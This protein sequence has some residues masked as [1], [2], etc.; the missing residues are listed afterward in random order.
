MPIEELVMAGGGTGLG[1]CWNYFRL[2]DR[3]GDKSEGRF[4]KLI[5]SLELNST[6]AKLH[7]LQLTLIFA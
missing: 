5:K 4:Q 6:N 2:I 7:I 1:Q 3:E